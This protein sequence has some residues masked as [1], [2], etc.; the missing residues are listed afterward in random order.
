MT[1][2][3]MK[4]EGGDKLAK[5]M[6]QAARQAP[7]TTEKLIHN[8][9]EKGKKKA[10]EYA[11]KPGGNRYSKNPY[12]TGYLKDHI[13]GTP[14]P[15][16]YEIKSPAYYTGYVNY[17]TRYMDKQPFFSDMWEEITE[18]AEDRFNDVLK[19]LLK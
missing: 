16:E 19:G 15:I 17:G 6:I 5:I 3:D 13:E 10:I 14:R 7:D 1:K 8:L 9:G 18:E 4:L 12:A 2:F 11:P